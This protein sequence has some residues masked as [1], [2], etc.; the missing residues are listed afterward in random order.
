MHLHEHGPA[1]RIYNTITYRWQSCAIWHIQTLTLGAALPCSTDCHA[2]FTMESCTPYC[3]L[4]YRY[5]SWWCM[6][7]CGIVIHSW[8]AGQSEESVSKM[9]H[10]MARALSQNWCMHIHYKNSTS[11]YEI[12]HWLSCCNKS[13]GKDSNPNPKSY[14]FLYTCCVSTFYQLWYSVV[15]C[16]ILQI[17]SC[18]AISKCME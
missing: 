17:F 15:Y 5:S 6:V 9:E 2:A 12:I 7:Y 3:V 14:M 16:C 8:R 4:L 18:V 1:L 11:L 13:I 10:T